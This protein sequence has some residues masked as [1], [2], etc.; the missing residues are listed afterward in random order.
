MRTQS[1][2]EVPLCF[3]PGWHIHTQ[4][5]PE[6]QAHTLLQPASDTHPGTATGA[7]PATARSAHGYSQVHQAHNSY[8]QVPAHNSMWPSIHPSS[9]MP[10][11]CSHQAA[12]PLN[13]PST[14]HAPDAPTCSTLQEIRPCCPTPATPHLLHSVCFF[15]CSAHASLL[16]TALLATAYSPPLLLPLLPTG[17]GLSGGLLATA[18]VV[19]IAVALLLLLL[20]ALSVR[21]LRYYDMLGHVSHARVW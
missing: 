6:D 18:I 20:A 16:A 14:P 21:R 4:V 1:R 8:Q 9:R 10:P 13:A 3:T 2:C 5:Q 17:D 12:Y 7:H 15:P 11:Q 19:P